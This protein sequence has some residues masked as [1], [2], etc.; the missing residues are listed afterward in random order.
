MFEREFET[1]GILK[2]H[3][4]DLTADEKSQ[5]EQWYKMKEGKSK[6]EDILHR[7]DM[8]GM[9]D[10][11]EQESYCADIIKYL[12]FAKYADKGKKPS[13]EM[14]QAYIKGFNKSKVDRLIGIQK[15]LGPQDVVNE[16]Q[17]EISKTGQELMGSSEAAR[18][19][20]MEKLMK[21]F[22][23]IGVKD[24][25]YV[26]SGDV[27]IDS[28]EFMT[29]K[30]H[31]PDCLYHTASLL[32]V[33][34]DPKPDQVENTTWREAKCVL[35]KVLSSVGAYVLVPICRTDGCAGFMKKKNAKCGAH[36]AHS[37]RVMRKPQ[38]RQ[39]QTE[40]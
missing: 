34:T 18:M 9:Q 28:K 33:T 22:E 40:G 23:H 26:G 30:N 32:G 13:Y 39:L 19:I 14:Y 17:R 3:E 10:M 38:L 11:T 20:A 6:I 7:S 5:L 35:D 21:N 12:R 4:E 37:K 8:H 1:T 16:C 15:G 31:L 25:R 29:D 24:L 36:A 27:V 2:K